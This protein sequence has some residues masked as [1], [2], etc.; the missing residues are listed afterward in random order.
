L[1][2]ISEIMRIHIEELEG[3][4]LDLE[5]SETPES[6]PVLQ[7]MADNGVCEFLTPLKAALRAQQ[8]DD[9]VQLEGSIATTVRLDCG[10]CLGSFEM[11]IESKFA[12]TYR[13][14][15]PAPDNSGPNH[16]E[17]ELTAEDMEL[18]HY[19]GEEINLENEIQ[20]QV[21][22]AFPIRPLCRPDCRGLCPACGADLNAA[23]C[24]CDR[25]PSGGKF[26]ALKNLK[27]K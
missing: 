25:S 7:E 20:E 17:L 15:A 18:I 16:E 10:R 21:V 12:L 6:F 24:D 14:R 22:L 11:P 8:I 23:N 5:F 26:D 27:L 13:Q 2:G 1:K 9:I 4:T 19:Q 3:G